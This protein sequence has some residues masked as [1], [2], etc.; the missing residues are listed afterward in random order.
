M[1]QASDDAPQV[2]DRRRRR[3]RRTTAG[4]SRRARRHGSSP[5][6]CVCRP[7]QQEV[8]T[9]RLRDTGCETSQNI[10]ASPLAPS[11]QGGDKRTLASQQRGARPSRQR[12]GCR[13]SAAAL[14]T[15]EEDVCPRLAEAY[16]AAP[17]R[18]ND[19]PFGSLR[20]GS[21]LP[22]ARAVKPLPRRAGLAELGGSGPLVVSASSPAM[23]TPATSPGW[24]GRR[25]PLQH[26][27]VGRELKAQ[28]RL[29]SAP[30]KTSPIRAFG[31]RQ[32]TG[33]CRVRLRG[34][35]ETNGEVGNT[36]H[37]RRCLEHGAEAFVCLPTTSGHT[38]SF[39]GRDA[40]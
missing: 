10:G 7:S 31:E 4:R 36:N 3:S 16:K 12:Q 38:H 2:A 6:P 27:L 1:V 5:T 34:A 9:Y 19:S 20:E 24:P 29:T 23:M 40:D 26:A 17:S 14:T 15:A 37:R 8:R 22:P 28:R 11:R 39:A 18:R 32:W 21:S 30:T 25:R 33:H 35:R 13:E